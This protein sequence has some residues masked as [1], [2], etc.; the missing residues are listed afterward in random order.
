MTLSLISGETGI[1]TLERCPLIYP[2]QSKYWFFA[3]NLV[4]AYVFQQNA[5]PVHPFT[6]FGYFL[7]DMVDR[8]LVRRGNNNV[9]LRA[10]ELWNFGPVSNGCL[11]ELNLAMQLNI[12]IKLFSIGNAISKIRPITVAE[13][14]FEDNALEIEAAESIRARLTSY[15]GQRVP[16][17]A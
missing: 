3:R 7:D 1:N 12:P 13:L 15:L 17:A 8:D 16:H 6:N 4:M 10:D 11:A 5:V 2:A 9:I 14:E